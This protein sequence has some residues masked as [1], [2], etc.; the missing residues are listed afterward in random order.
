M[1][2]GRSYWAVS[3]SGVQLIMVVFAEEGEGLFLKANLEKLP[4]RGGQ[5]CGGTLQGHLLI[6]HSS[7]VANPP[8][9]P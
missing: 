9:S 1:G 6:R 8:L 4:Q 2:G 3:M 7:D 5:E